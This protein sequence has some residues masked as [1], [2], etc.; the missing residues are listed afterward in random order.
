LE[1]KKALID[2]QRPMQQEDEM[3]KDIEKK[4]ATSEL[5]RQKQEAE[6]ARQKT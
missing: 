1:E 6:V 4:K 2:L 5:L 3:V